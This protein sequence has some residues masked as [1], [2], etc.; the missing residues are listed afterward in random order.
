MDFTVTKQT[1]DKEGKGKKTTLSDVGW[2]SVTKQTRD[3]EGKEK[4]TKKATALIQ[5]DRTVVRHPVVTHLK[6]GNFL[7]NLPHSQR[8]LKLKIKRLIVP[9]AKTEILSANFIHSDHSQRLMGCFGRVFPL[10][11]G[12]LVPRLQLY[13]KW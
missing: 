5:S 3:K 6:R 10:E 8:S 11:F 7:Y 9:L 12:S 2:I 1:K 13:E 4:T